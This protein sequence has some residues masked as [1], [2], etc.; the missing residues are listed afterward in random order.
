MRKVKIEIDKCYF[1][2]KIDELGKVVL[3]IEIREALKIKEADTLKIYIDNGKIVI[4]NRY[5][6]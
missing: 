3:P 1:L 2:R 5:V 6:I 4:E